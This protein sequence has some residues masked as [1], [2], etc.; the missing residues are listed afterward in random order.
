[1]IELFVAVI[2]TTGLRYLLLPVSIVP[3]LGVLSSL[4]FLS[5]TSDRFW[6][7]LLVIFAGAAVQLFEYFFSNYRKVFL[8][9]RMSMNLRDFP[10]E[11]DANDRRL[12]TLT[13][14]PALLLLFLLIYGGMFLVRIPSIHPFVFSIF[15]SLISVLL[16]SFRSYVKVPTWS[17]NGRQNYPSEKFYPIHIAARSGDVEALRKI[18]QNQKK[19]INRKTNKGMAPIHLTIAGN[20][21]DATRLLVESGADLNLLDGSFKRHTPLMKAAEMNDRETVEFLLEKGAD[22][23]I[24]STERNN[25]LYFSKEHLELIQL[26]VEHKVDYNHINLLDQ[27]LLSIASRMEEDFKPHPRSYPLVKYLLELG[28]PPD[29]LPMEK[30]RPLVEAV[31]ADNLDVVQ[32]LLEKGANPNVKD[33]FQ[34]TA[35]IEAV[36]RGSLK[37]VELLIKAGADPNLTGSAV[38]LYREE[39]APLEYAKKLIDDSIFDDDRLGSRKAIISLLIRSSAK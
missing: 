34:G 21:F 26:F 38:H 7:I 14:L 17:P 1:M 8:N 24:L 35:L 27:S 6:L 22:P 18:L 4:N 32:L 9:V 31:E 12:Y 11:A 30:S 28:I 25:I 29:G 10:E 39:V 13:F 20:H 5:E 16:I 37:M 3:L 2:F 15:F 33:Q 23:N 36:S 19:Q